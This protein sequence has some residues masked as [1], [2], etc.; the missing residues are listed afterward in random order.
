MSKLMKRRDVLKLAGLTG[1]GA[2]LVA[3]APA[4]TQAPQAAAAT[5]APATTVPA[6][7]VPPTTAPAVVKAADKILV[8]GSVSFTKAGDAQLAENMAE[9]GKANNIEVEYVALPGSDYTAKIAAAVETGAIPDALLFTG[10]DSI[11]YAQRDKLV[12]MT[13]VYDSV[14]GLAG[15]IYES[16]SPNV[17]ADGKYYGVPMQADVSCLYAR[18]DLCAEATGKR[19][20][21]K[22]I[23]EMDAIMRKLNKPPKLHGLGWPLGLTP[24]SN[25]NLM[26]IM[27]NDG[28]TLVDAQGNPSINSDGTV[29]ALTRLEA[30]WKDKLIPADAPTADD[31]SNNRWYQGK[32]AVF[33]MN[34][35]SIFAFLDAN[36]K[37][38]L[39]DTI[40]APMPS[41]RAGS[42]PSAGCW[43]FSVFK[44]SK[45]IDPAKAMI[46]A[47]LHPDK[48]G[49]VYEKVGGRWFPMYRDLA[50]TKFWAD[51]PFFNE[52]PNILESARPQWHPAPATPKL[53]GQLS[54]TWQKFV[55]A[56]MAQ[57][58]VINGKSPKQ[59]AEAG[60]VKMEQ[61]F[62]EAAK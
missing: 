24:D 17:M 23:D 7:T 16:L 30:W 22:T 26:W 60:Q 49:P 32:Y 8:W 14:K 55:Y 62:A 45:M 1:A 34:P 38:L 9:W 61:V 51:R 31:G 57:D 2:A 58:I 40:Q 4:A 33:V 35:A 44:D 37:P 41:G 36:D 39:A 6:T 10:T 18:L 46:K 20:A 48:M 11:Y 50:K 52:F 42:F 12:D 21:P 54:A 59:A 47:I 43:A 5:T 53:L 56:E 13:D 28:A 25:G 27:L 29:S 19:E 15:G 3:C